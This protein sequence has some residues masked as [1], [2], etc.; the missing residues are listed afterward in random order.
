KQVRDVAISWLL[1]QGEA[2]IEQVCPLFADKSAYTRLAVVEILVRLHLGAERTH[3]LLAGQREIE[4]TANVKQALVDPIG[5]PGPPADID[6]AVAIAEL[7]TEAVSGG[8]KSPLRWYAAEEPTG[9]RWVNGT[10][11][12]PAVIYY[13]LACQARMKQMQL[14]MNVRRVLRWLDRQ[15]TGE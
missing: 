11:V 2:L 5:R 12:P 7:L 13:L 6:P 4:K 14:E 8:K 1:P 3:A 10:S 9:L 15:T